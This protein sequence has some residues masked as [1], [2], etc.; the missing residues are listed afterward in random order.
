[1]AEPVT[2]LRTPRVY[3]GDASGAP[4]TQPSTRRM[5]VCLKDK[6]DENNGQSA[7]RTSYGFHPLRRNPEFPSVAGDSGGKPGERVVSR[8]DR[9]SVKTPPLQTSVKQAGKASGTERPGGKLRRVG[10]AEATSPRA[11]LMVARCSGMLPPGFASTSKRQQRENPSAAAKA[12]SAQRAAGGG[13]RV[14]ANSQETSGLGVRR[15]TVCGSGKN[16]ST[17]SGVPAEKPRVGKGFAQTKSA[18][19]SASG[20]AVLRRPSIRE[21]K[22]SQVMRQAT[23]RSSVVSNF[24]PARP[25]S[26]A[27][28]WL[29]KGTASS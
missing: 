2:R 26:Y 29:P 23:E 24:L 6:R 11:R 1:M 13:T 14:S 8:R 28:P 10:T 18:S 17:A 5:L 19:S 15:A 20:Q 22:V 7:V 16:S 12:P 27:R 3:A 25:R 21:A 9:T 4:E